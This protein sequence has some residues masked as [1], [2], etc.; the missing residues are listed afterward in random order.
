MSRKFKDA[1]Y[2]EID[3]ADA[4]HTH[5]WVTVNGADGSVIELIEQYPIADRERAFALAR[6]MADLLDLPVKLLKDRD[7]PAQPISDVVPDAA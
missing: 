7:E 3:D 4:E 2:I 1:Y 6:R 5:L